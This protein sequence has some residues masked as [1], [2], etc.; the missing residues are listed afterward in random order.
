MGLCVLEYRSLSLL[1]NICCHELSV[2]FQQ[3]LETSFLWV[4]YNG[5]ETADVYLSRSYWEK[6]CGLCGTFDG[7]K[8]ND[9]L[10]PNGELVN[11]FINPCS[12]LVEAIVL[13]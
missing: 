4:T 7:D 2:H 13:Q 12:S 6:T 9:F 8:S 5:R 11:T 3:S 1:K 10:M